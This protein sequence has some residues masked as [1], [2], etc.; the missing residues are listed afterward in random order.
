MYIILLNNEH[1]NAY[2]KTK[3][4][5]QALM[6]QVVFSHCWRSSNTTYICTRGHGAGLGGP[7]ADG[8][9]N[10]VF[11]IIIC[12]THKVHYVKLTKYTVSKLCLLSKYVIV[13]MFT[14]DWTCH[15]RNI[16]CS[17]YY[18]ILSVLRFVLNKYNDFNFML[19][20]DWTHSTAWGTCALPIRR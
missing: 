20:V 11:D 6:M 5:G 15:R 8:T 16:V 19:I 2:I 14:S 10:M 4:R 12:A 1:I 17:V 9:T 3:G 18:S 13:V 7:C